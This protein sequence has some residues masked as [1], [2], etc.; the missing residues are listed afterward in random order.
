MVPSGN[1]INQYI[2]MNVSE[3]ILSA[4]N[5]SIKTEFKKNYI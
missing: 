5:R 1:E 3:M 2:L 4:I